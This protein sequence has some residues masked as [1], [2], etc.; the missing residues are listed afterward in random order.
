MIFN[1]N[2]QIGFF[3]R[4]QFIE[5][6]FACLLGMSLLYAYE[7]VTYSESAQTLFRMINEQSFVIEDGHFA[8]YIMQFLPWVFIKLGIQIQAVGTIFG[9]SYFL[10]YCGIFLIIKNVFLE[11]RIAVL[12]LLLLVLA[13]PETFFDVTSSSKQAMAIGCL[14]FACRQSKVIAANRLILVSILI[15]LIG[16]GTH[17][18]FFM[19]VFM[20]HL[21]QY[22]FE[23]KFDYQIG[24]VV[25]SLIFAWYI[26]FGKTIIDCDVFNITAINGFIKKSTLHNYLLE[27]FWSR[28]KFIGICFFFSV[29]YLWKTKMYKAVWG[30]ALLVLFTYLAIFIIN[31]SW[32]DYLQIQNTMFVFHFALLV[33][34]FFVLDK[35]NVQRQ[36]LVKIGVVVSL[37]MSIGT[38]I[39]IDKVYKSRASRLQYKLEVLKPLGNKFI[40]GEHQIDTTIFLRTND[41]PYETA[42][43]S[44]WKLNSG[45]TMKNMS[46]TIDSNQLQMTSGIFLEG[47]GATIQLEQMNKTYFDFSNQPYSV[48]DN[49]FRLK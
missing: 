15:L 39:Q 30:S 38:L 4:Y 18:I 33:P 23:K 11:G 9:F 36:W 37:I 29:A 17:P 13:V 35:L 5:Y 3:K 19:Y 32:V 49:G 7:S 12:F 31:S 26:V 34:L 24:I 16:A 1:F 28:Y 10:F 43:I 42:I 8:N 44:A 45:L 21:Y 6:F 2:N 46:D 47:D 27:V 41:L 20:V 40:I 22:L 25:V 14:Y 48:I